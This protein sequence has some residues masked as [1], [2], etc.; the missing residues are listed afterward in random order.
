MVDASVKSL[1]RSRRYRHAG[2]FREDS[3]RSKQVR[4]AASC[5][6]SITEDAERKWEQ[7][8]E[9]EGEIEKAR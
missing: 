8:T 7:E 4:K 5:R 3:A 2:C 1:T 9:R 6:V